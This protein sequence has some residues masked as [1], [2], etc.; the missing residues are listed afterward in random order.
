MIWTG[1][2]LVFIAGILVAKLMGSVLSVGFSALVLKNAHDDYVRL[3]AQLS[4]TIF[5]VQQLKTMEM[6]RLGKSAKEIEIS[7]TLSE[8]NLKPLKEAMIKNFLNTFPKKYEGLVKF[9][10]W[11]SAMVHMEE[12]IKED[13]QKLNK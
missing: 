2:V 4:Q 3:V 7:R 13:R 10:D 1:Y 9:S 8:Y 5:E 6:H 12:L 11:E